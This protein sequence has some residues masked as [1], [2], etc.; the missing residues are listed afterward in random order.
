MQSMLPVGR[1]KNQPIVWRCGNPLCSKGTGKRFFDFTTRSEK[2]KCTRCGAEPP[3][4]AAR[5]LIHMLVSDP[6]GPIVGGHGVRYKIPCEPT[7]EVM[8]TEGNQEACSGDFRAVN[9]P[10]CLALL[11]EKHLVSGY[12]LSL[13]K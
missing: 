11:G 8:A 1:T 2:P 3:F 7:R 9:C 4:V 10:G 5:S 12:S 6:S 13:H